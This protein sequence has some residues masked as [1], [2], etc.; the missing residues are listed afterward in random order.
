M[1]RDIVVAI[2]EWA[3]ADDSMIISM[4]RICLLLVI[5]VGIVVSPLIYHDYRAPKISLFKAEW[6]CTQSH[7]VYVWIS[8]GKFGGSMVPEEICDMYVRK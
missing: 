7:T 8:K 6:T 4:A 5:I 2:E 1:I 3:V